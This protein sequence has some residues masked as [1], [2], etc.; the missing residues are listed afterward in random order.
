MWFFFFSF[1]FIHFPFSYPFP[2]LLLQLPLRYFKEPEHFDPNRFSP[3]NVE[4][5][6][7][8]A[9]V[10]FSAGPRNCIGQRFAVL[11]EKSIISAIIRHF[12]LKAVM[13]REQIKIVQELVLR[14]V[15]AIH[16]Q[17]QRR[18]WFERLNLPCNYLEE[19]WTEKL[20]KK[21][22]RSHCIKIFIQASKPNGELFYGTWKIVFLFHRIFLSSNIFPPPAFNRFSDATMKTFLSVHGRNFPPSRRER[23]V[24]NLLNKFTDLI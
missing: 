22:L 13:R 8:Y 21:K 5:R 19:L 9:F 24:I 7:S 6:H 16:L 15:N 3:E 1:V 11:E 2:S 12:K 23:N 17:F 10:P 14:P 20:A 4:G 18:Q